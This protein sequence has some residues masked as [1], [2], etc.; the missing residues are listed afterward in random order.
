M[1]YTLKKKL[2]NT[3]WILGEELHGTVDH[4]YLEKNGGKTKSFGEND[5]QY[6][7]MVRTRNKK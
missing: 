4:E 5:K 7:G 3:K 6:V 1:D 2:L